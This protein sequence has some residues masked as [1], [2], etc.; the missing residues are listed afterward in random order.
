MATAN[1]KKM[2]QWDPTDVKAELLKKYPPRWPAN[3]P[4]R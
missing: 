4:S 1:K 2:V 3:A